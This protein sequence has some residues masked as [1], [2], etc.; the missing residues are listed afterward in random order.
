MVKQSVNEFYNWFLFKIDSLLQDFAFSLDIDPTF[1]NKLS[2]DVRELLISEGVQ[3]PPRP[4]TEN[5]HKGNQRLILV[6]NTAV[7]A[8]KKTRTI[9]S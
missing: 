9:N 4:P 6:R 5:N 2:P 1:F 3:V 7:E 8:E